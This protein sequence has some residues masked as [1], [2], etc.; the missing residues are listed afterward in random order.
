MTTVLDVIDRG[1]RRIILSKIRWKHIASKH[2]DVNLHDIERALKSPTAILPED[3]STQKRDYYLRRKDKG[4]YLMVCV[5]YIN[6]IGHVLTA[7]RTR[8]IPKS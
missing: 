2:P 5:T 6:A 8:K 1:G 3:L 7:F 4:D